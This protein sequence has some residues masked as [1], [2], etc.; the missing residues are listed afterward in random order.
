L[1]APELTEIAIVAICCLTGTFVPITFA[2]EMGRKTRTILRLRQLRRS[3]EMTQADL[4]E[5]VGLPRSTICLIEKGIR[6]PAL[7]DARAIAEVFGEP[8]ESVFGQVEVP[9]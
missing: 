6:Q 5:R 7:D 4:A 2:P 1:C 9:V 8:I 3:R